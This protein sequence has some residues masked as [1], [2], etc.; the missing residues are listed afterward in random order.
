MDFTSHCRFGDTAEETIW[1]Q[2]H[3]TVANYL[4]LKKSFRSEELD[5]RRT[6]THINKEFKKKKKEK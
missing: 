1:Q 2:Q 6:Q 5:E 3:K 4:I